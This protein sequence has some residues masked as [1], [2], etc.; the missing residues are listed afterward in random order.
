MYRLNVQ[1][2]AYGQQTVADMGVVRSCDP[3]EIF[4]LQSYYWNGWA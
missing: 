4:G 3:F 2:T 1:V